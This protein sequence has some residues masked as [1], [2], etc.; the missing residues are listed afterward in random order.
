MKTS[1]H[2]SDYETPREWAL[3]PSSHRP[4]GSAQILRGGLV[5]WLQTA[6]P[7][8]TTSSQGIARSPTIPHV[9]TP[10]TLLVA[11]MIAEV[12]P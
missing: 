11:A 7:L 8:P 9:S 4:S 10:L 12:F 3:H 6:H 2:E 1:W 5:S